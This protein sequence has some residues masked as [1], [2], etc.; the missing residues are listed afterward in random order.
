MEA[1]RYHRGARA[2]LE[3]HGKTGRLITDQPRYKLHSQLDHSPISRAGKILGREPVTLHTDDAR[4]MDLSDGDIVR[5]FNAR[6][7]CLA[8]VVCTD[9]IRR[10][11]IRIS[12]G[13]WFDPATTPDGQPLD[14]HGN[15]N[16][17]TRDEGTSRLSQGCAA[18]SCLVSIERYEGELPPVR[19]FTAP[20]FVSA[21]TASRS[22]P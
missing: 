3:R 2:I 7:A 22:Q 6:G 21:S 11:V 9:N 19:A 10:G 12:T 20:A 16:V 17:L 4:S 8:A 15:P 1:A 13:S 14:V 18:Q 5:V